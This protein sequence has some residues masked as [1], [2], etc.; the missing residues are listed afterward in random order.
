MVKKSAAKSNGIVI[1][2]KGTS[3]RILDIGQDG[4]KTEFSNKGPITGRYRG[5][6]WDTVEAQMN[7]NGTSSWRVRF[8]QMTDKGD[9]LVGT[10]E[11][12]GEA[13]N[14]R[15]IAKLKGSGTVMT[16]SPRLAE[17]NGRGWTCDV[18][19]NVAADTAVVRVT[20]Q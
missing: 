17:L 6:H 18:D 20:F 5:T 8:I 14:S 2:A 15:G 19:Q 7:A 9:M 12:T 11:G 1:K 4:I 3:C 16:M 13:P 10:G